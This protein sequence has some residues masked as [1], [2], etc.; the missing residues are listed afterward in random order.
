MGMA[1]LYMVGQDLV[2][3]ARLENVGG[4][5]RQSRESGVGMGGF[6]VRA[7]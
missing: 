3:R 4:S 5:D 7:E 2:G 1:S 6:G